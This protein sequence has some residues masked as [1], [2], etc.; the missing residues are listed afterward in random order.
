[1]G[2]GLA[3]VP[4][5]TWVGGR[6]AQTLS[7]TFACENTVGAWLRAV[8][9][10]G[11][12]P[13]AHPL[14]LRVPLARRAPLWRVPRRLAPRR[15]F[16]AL[17]TLVVHWR[18]IIRG[19]D[20][21]AAHCPKACR[22]ASNSADV[23]MARR[24]RS[25]CGLGAATRARAKTSRDSAPQLTRATKLLSCAS[26]AAQSKYCMRASAM[27]S[28]RANISALNSDHS[29]PRSCAAIENRTKIREA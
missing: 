13:C 5:R 3:R 19:G 2:A 12:W 8:P 28:R 15:R 20:L 16:S 7:P 25:A 27:S 6:A 9:D 14:P 1:M 18:H 22:F 26:E 4:S 24:A 23:L 29:F 11:G 10:F 21:V 17:S